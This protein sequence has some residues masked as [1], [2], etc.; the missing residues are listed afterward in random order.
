MDVKV[1]ICPHIS[2]DG[3]FL[4]DNGTNSPLF[5]VLGNDVEYSPNSAILSPMKNNWYRTLQYQNT[6][7]TRSK[8]LTNQSIKQ[9]HQVSHNTATP[10]LQQHNFSTPP[11][12][13]QAIPL[14]IHLTT[15]S[16]THPAT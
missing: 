3:E 5:R 11:V 16:A 10:S 15:H 14:E 13:N 6:P 4:G 12:N 2:D 8:L 9:T 1:Y 7:E